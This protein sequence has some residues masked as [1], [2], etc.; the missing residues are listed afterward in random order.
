MKTKVS[1]F[2]RILYFQFKAYYKTALKY[3]L[4][5]V[6]ISTDGSSIQ[7]NVDG[8]TSNSPASGGSEEDDDKER[9]CMGMFSVYIFSGVTSNGNAY[10]YAVLNSEQYQ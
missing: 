1:T 3:T 7:Q 4:I 10:I 5:D 9:K 6:C 8:D 2:G